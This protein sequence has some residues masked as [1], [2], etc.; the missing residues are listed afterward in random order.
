MLRFPLCLSLSLKFGYGAAQDIRF[1]ICLQIAKLLFTAV[2]CSDIIAV[3][4]C[5][6]FAATLRQSFRQGC[7]KAG[8]LLQPYRF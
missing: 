7:S 4:T 1:R 2:R 3:H 8:I 5:H 6:P